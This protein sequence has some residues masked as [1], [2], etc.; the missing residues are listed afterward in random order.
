MARLTQF[1]GLFTKADAAE[2]QVMAQI[3]LR[4]AHRAHLGIVE[5]RGIREVRIGNRPLPGGSS[6][7]CGR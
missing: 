4:Q 2:R 5:R 3:A 7:G 6:E 1:K